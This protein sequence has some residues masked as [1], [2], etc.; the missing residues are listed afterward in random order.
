MPK[1]A[2]RAAADGVQR[3]DLIRGMCVGDWMEGRE[4]GDWVRHEDVA[5]IIRTKVEREQN[6]IL[7]RIGERY[8]DQMDSHTDG[9]I[10]NIENIIRIRQG[11][12]S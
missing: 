7:A 8:P 9:V 4:D 3:Y 6:I 10:R 11:G 1:D 2:I 12:E 5:A